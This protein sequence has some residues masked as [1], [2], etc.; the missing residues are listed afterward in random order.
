MHEKLKSIKGSITVFLSLIMVA[1]LSFVSTF[2]ESARIQVAKMEVKRCLC[3]STDAVLTNY[4]KPLYE[5]YGVFFLDKGIDSQSIENRVLSR[6]IKTYMEESLSSINTNVLTST[7]WETKGTNL[8]MP[9]IQSVS[10]DSAIYAVDDKGS[11]F[12]DQAIQYMKYIAPADSLQEMMGVLE[13]VQEGEATSKIMEKEIEAEEAFG[14]SSEYLLRLM[15]LI[16][17]VDSND[18]GFVFMENGKIKSVSSYAKKIVFGEVTKGTVGV[19]NETVYQSMKSEYVNIQQKL[20]EIQKE[21]KDINDGK[22]EEIKKKIKEI[23]KMQKEQKEVVSDTIKCIEKART[24]IGKLES[25]FPAIEKKIENYNKAL[26]K[27][28]KNLSKEE[29]KNKVAVKSQLNQDLSQLRAVTAMDESLKKNRDIL[30][31]L[32]EELSISLSEETGQEKYTSI[33][34]QIEK[35]SQYSISQLVFSYGKMESVKETKDP[36]TILDSIGESVLELVVCDV[37]KIS[38][39]ALEN[40]DYYY[41]KYV[42]KDKKIDRISFENPFENIAQLLGNGE[43]LTENITERLLFQAYIKEHFKSYISQEKSDSSLDYE[44]EYILCGEKSDKKNL[45]DTVEYIALIRM[46]PN[47][48]YLLSDT[49]ARQSA[50]TTAAGLV[51]FTGLEPLIRATQMAILLVWAYEESLVDVSALLEGKEIAF[52]KNKKSFSIKYDEILQF[53]KNLIAKKV[54]EI[55]TKSSAKGTLSYEDYL[56]ILM[57]LKDESKKVYRSMDII[58][59]NMQLRY[60]SKFSMEDCIYALEVSCGYEIPKKF[61]S[62]G[63]YEHSTKN[64]N[65]WF[66][67]TTTKYSY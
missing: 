39:K 33:E 54:K 63:F 44:Q 34:G 46:L 21:L 43:E 29:Y 57:I 32:E 20:R 40:P 35:L 27:E 5:D 59:E 4:Y 52:V 16:E 6:E 23:N 7:T 66:Y 19:E 48:S 42:G 13:V 12:Y 64:N 17:G 65:S 50:Y 9:Q 60:S 51:G 28:E 22:V 55:K 56:T 24:V 11:S 26:K 8:Y 14:N 38:D 18:T 25:E 30:M 61:L 36:T 53:N 37:D 62:F 31:G 1:V 15:E 67:T 45:E 3:G 49:K 47:F 58:E 2:L 10:V 41:E